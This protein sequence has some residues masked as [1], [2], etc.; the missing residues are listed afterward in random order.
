MK[1]IAVINYG[2]GNLHSIMNGLKKVKVPAVLTTSA[3][4]AGKCAGIII[5]GVGAFG[6][7]VKELKKR[8]LFGFLKKA[9]AKNTPVLGICLGMQLLFEES[10]EFGK[11]KG[12]GFIKG[13][14]KKFGRNLKVP[15]M[16]WNRVYKTK[17]NNRVL[18]NIKNGEFFYFVHSYYAAPDISASVLTKT[19]Y[20]NII[21]TSGVNRDNIYGFQFH[22]EK[23]GEKTLKIYRN[24]YELAVKNNK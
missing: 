19:K 11:I 14:V 20:D 4:T 16:G 1:K 13:K 24:F 18:K 9:A 12:L 7:A 8:K 21:F 6:D 23:S 5:P 10:S 15:H 2:M 3:A 22:P 17:K